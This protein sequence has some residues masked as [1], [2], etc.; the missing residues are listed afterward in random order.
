MEGFYFHGFEVIVL[1]E[2]LEYSGYTEG[3]LIPRGKM[4]WVSGGIPKEVYDALNQQQMMGPVERY[5]KVRMTGKFEYGGQYGHL[6]A[7]AKQITP[8][9]TEILSWSVPVSET[10]KGNGFAIYLLADD[11]PVS[12]MPIMSHFEP[13][14]KPFLSLEDIVFYIRETHEI[15]LTTSAIDRVRSLG[16]LVSGKPF[17]VCVERQQIY[18]GAFWTPF[19]SL[20]F[21]GVTIGKPVSP[22]QNSIRLELGYPARS[23]FR[24]EDPRSDPVIMQSL[25]EAGKLK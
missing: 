25:E 18:W 4:I 5:G 10:P 15:G 11:I 17:V 14:E 19:S 7:Y 12:Q 16:V 24:G 2:N 8:T 3:H 6:G 9:R 20:S 22:E 13:E 23:F 21:N 1:S